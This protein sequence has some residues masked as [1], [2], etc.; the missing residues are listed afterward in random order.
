MIHVFEIP[1]A[2]RRQ[3]LSPTDVRRLAKSSLADDGA[4]QTEEAEHEEADAEE[5]FFGGSRLSSTCESFVRE[6]VG[7]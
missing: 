5:R 2:S 4:Q 6:A 1:S 3:L 7:P